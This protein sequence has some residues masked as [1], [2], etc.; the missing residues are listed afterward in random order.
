[1]QGLRKGV[2]YGGGGNPDEP[3]GEQEASDL[4]EE[5]SLG[6]YF[7]EH[8]PGE[9]AILPSVKDSGYGSCPEGA[10]DEL[11]DEDLGRNGRPV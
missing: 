1:M 9:G 8:G 11:V 6:R 10:V 3:S 7:A 5:R 4:E 2:N